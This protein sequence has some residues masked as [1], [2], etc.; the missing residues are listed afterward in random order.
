[1][2][3]RFSLVVLVVNLQQ[4]NF[5]HQIEVKIRLIGNWLGLCGIDLTQVSYYLAIKAYTCATIRNCTD[6]V[7]GLLPDYDNCLRGM[8][9]TVDSVDII[10]YVMLLIYCHWL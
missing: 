7:S 3:S 1:M 9:S 6:Q 8:A 5:N 2:L 10:D 4:S